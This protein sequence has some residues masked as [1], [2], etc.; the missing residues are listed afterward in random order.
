MI[1]SFSQMLRVTVALAGVVAANF[2]VTAGLLWL[3][4]EWQPRPGSRFFLNQLHQVGFGILLSQV[5]LIGYWLGLADGR[6]YL[7]LVAANAMTLATALAIHWA[8]ALSPTARRGG[9]DDPWAIIGFILIA[10]MLTVSFVGF[11]LR[12]PRGWRLTWRQSMDFPVTHQF[13]IADALLWMIVIS[14]ALAAI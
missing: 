3:M 9:D 8:D 1:S 13:Q 4:Q 12:R 10:M 7:R 14:G 11:V 6:W 2:A 5:V